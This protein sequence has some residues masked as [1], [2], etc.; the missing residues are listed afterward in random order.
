MLKFMMLF[1]S[2]LY[3]YSSVGVAADSTARAEK[4]T[5]VQ[6]IELLFANADDEAK[7]Q[8]NEIRKMPGYK[9]K[10]PSK[11][12]NNDI[13]YLLMI[14]EAKAA[15]LYSLA[16]QFTEN[17]PIDAAELLFK[18]VNQGDPK[19]KNAM[20]HYTSLTPAKKEKNAKLLCAHLKELNS[21]Q[22]NGKKLTI[23]SKDTKNADELYEIGLRFQNLS[24]KK[25]AQKQR[26]K[27]DMLKHFKLAADQDHP[28]AIASLISIY[29]SEGKED[30]LKLAS[31]KADKGL[32]VGQFELAK[33][34]LRDQTPENIE[35]ARTLL[36]SAA[37]QGYLE[38]E[39]ELKLLGKEENRMDSIFAK[40][41]QLGWSADIFSVVRALKIT[42]T[43][44][45][46]ESQYHL[47]V[48]L[49]SGQYNIEK[50]PEEGK[51]WLRIATK[52]K[53]APAKFALAEFLFTEAVNSKSDLSAKEAFQLLK[54]LHINFH[55][56]KGL[57]KEEFSAIRALLHR[58]YK[59]GIGIKRNI[60]MA[61]ELAMSANL[62]KDERVVRVPKLNSAEAWSR[63]KAGADEGKIQ[64]I[65][66]MA[67]HH[68]FGSVGHQNYLKAV[69]YLEIAAQKGSNEAKGWL[70]MLA[71][72]EK[73]HIRE[74]YGIVALEYGSPN[75]F[76]FS[77]ALG[78]LRG[79]GG[80]QDIEKAH[81]FFDQLNFNHLI[82]RMFVENMRR[83]TP[84]VLAYEPEA[85][86]QWGQ[87]KITNAPKQ[88]LGALIVAAYLGHRES[89]FELGKY[90]Q[91]SAKAKYSET[92][93]FWFQIAALFQHEGARKE[94]LRMEEEPKAA[95]APAASIPK[96]KKKI[97]RDVIPMT[98]KAPID[99]ATLAISAYKPDLSLD[100]ERK[101]AEEEFA[102]HLK[103]ANNGDS[104]AQVKVGC[105]YYKKDEPGKA[106][107]HFLHALTDANLSS[108]DKSLALRKMQ[109]ID[110]TFVFNPDNIFASSN[111]NSFYMTKFSHNKKFLN[112]YEVAVP[113]EEPTSQ[114]LTEIPVIK[115]KSLE[116]EIAPR[117]DKNIKDLDIKLNELEK[118]VEIL[119][120]EPEKGDVLQD[121]NGIPVRK[122]RF[123]ID[124]E[125]VG[126]VAYLYI[127][128]HNKIILLAAI[129]KGQNDDFSH[130]EKLAMIEFLTK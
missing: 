86:Y 47:G 5:L 43:R 113:F 11:P 111:R 10:T 67:L 50:N 99:Q 119:Q 106:K 79:I 63:D 68:I 48:I 21:S 95:L 26:A 77:A 1:V 90:L 124:K 15:N 110:S 78:Y 117:F 34:L 20:L 40:F 16:V 45:D 82:E 115:E 54:E 25:P 85:L 91:S 109:K 51:Y 60:R 73:G 89:Q 81:R 128:K 3:I 38:A 57:G 65:I 76:T 88:A 31:E 52:N 19:A 42:A 14:R 93:F 59:E 27:Q 112:P 80:P 6:K 53:H 9:N 7:K 98:Y 2:F 39:E 87:E 56:E 44:G 108:H 4:A 100:L 120:C 35:K 114:A 122:A 41:A 97:K 70:V 13:S 8:L 102:E 18:A 96:N 103:A 123:R 104:H 17:F 58:C 46:S 64:S 92:A 107:E 23:I 127:P 130:E 49:V 29:K 75:Y 24:I 55:D 83:L 84:E 32:A 74:D 33:I 69:K 125:N 36:N 66:M 28:E 62:E 12:S 101:S 116:F 94:L 22:N 72:L 105:Y 121:L 71:M 126:R 129:K 118:L 37:S 30:A 61:N